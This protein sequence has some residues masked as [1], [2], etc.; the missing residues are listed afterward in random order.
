MHQ[1]G[2]ALKQKGYRITGSDDDIYEP[3]RGNLEKAG[4]LPATPGWHPERIT[5][6]LDAVILGMHARP[7]NP[8]IARAQ[9]LNIPM[10]SFPEYIYKESAAKLRIVIG[11][12]HGKTTITAMIMHVL[13]YCGNDFDYL[14]G[15]KIPGFD[16]SVKLSD[17]PIMICEGDEY[18]SS[19]LLKKPKFLFYH[20]NIAVLSG[21]AWDHM[22]V[23]PT[24]DIYLHQFA[25][26]IRQMEPRSVL[27]YNRLD[28]DLTTLV[29]ENGGHLQSIPYEILPYRVT[30][31]KTYIHK[32]N[33]E[34]PLQVFGAHNLQNIAAARLVCRELHIADEDFLSAISSFSGASRR[35]EKV[36]EKPEALFFRDFAH[37][38]S[39]VKASIH[40]V[41][42]QFPD[43]RLLA[44]LE[45]HTY[46]SLN[47]GF[48]S[49]YKNAMDEADVAGVFYSEHALETKRLPPLSP[50]EIRGGF[51]NPH[52][53][54]LNRPEDLKDFIG[55]LPADQA[56]L[57]MMSS[58]TFGGI[59][60]GE[61]TNLWQK[62]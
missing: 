53:Q 27:I 12:S 40:A 30:N 38:P 5:P 45:L 18:P 62:N 59:T 36:F 9:R 60:P 13:Q 34:V 22:N 2:I 16:Y 57:L 55:R 24:Y 48:L 15:A 11:G 26:F 47:A 35:L 46:S 19:A 23:F 6:D 51:G 28:R 43:R 3:A 4:I 14:V 50:E 49:Q 1:L 21:I 25:L 37:A 7:D 8:E 20:P 31:G 33:T 10:F 44:L 42:E 58:G 39:K 52:L 41:K 32:G 29:E 54:V 61:I 56:N 17:A